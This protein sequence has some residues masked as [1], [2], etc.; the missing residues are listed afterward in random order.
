MTEVD[1]SVQKYHGMIENVVLVR[2]LKTKNIL[3]FFCN[4][5]SNLRSD[6]LT[7]LN[8][9]TDYQELKPKSYESITLLNKLLNPQTID[10]VK[11]ISYFT[12]ISSALSLR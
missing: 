6:L 10:N 8:I 9:Q 7:K 3:C 5:F 2:W 12:S 4:K 11:L 1:I